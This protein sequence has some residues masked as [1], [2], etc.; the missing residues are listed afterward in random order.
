MQLKNRLL[1]FAWFFYFCSLPLFKAFASIAEVAL[2][3]LSLWP[4]TFSGLKHS[5]LRYKAVAAITLIFGILLLG[6]LY[7]EDLN[8]GYKILKH[9]HRFLVIPLLFLVHANLLQENFR[10]L[11]FAFILATALACAFTVLLYFLPEATV[12]TL[13][14]STNLLIDYP[15]NINRTAF[16]LY[17][18]FID[19][20][21]FSSITAVA[22][23]SS[24]YLIITGYRR[25]ALLAALP[26]LFYTMLILGGRGAQ[27]ALFGALVVYAVIISVSLLAPKL[28][29]RWGKWPGRFFLFVAGL[30]FF[31][32]LPYL[33]FKTMEPIQTRVSQTEWEIDL[34][35]KQEYKNFDYEHFTTFR[36]I[37]SMKNMWEVVKQNPILGVGTG[38]YKAEIKKAYAKNNPEFEV[39]N[40]S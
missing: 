18:P 24:L 20:I 22:I 36:R 19:R 30:L 6:M 7:T 15:D 35:Q 34:L 12:R 40:H 27:L 4:G 26:L 2:V 31:I 33:S 17:T 23:I 39:N 37:I 29:V 32:G 14:N 10:K 8:S 28:A 9:Q 38:D 11:T 1:L 5:V 13:A 21:Q 25:K 16:G 3:I